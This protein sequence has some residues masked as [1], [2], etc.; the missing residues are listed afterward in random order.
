[1]KKNV[2][3][4]WH[5]SGSAKMGKQQDRLSVV[6]S[7]LKVHGYNNLRV[8]DLSVTPILPR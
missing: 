8:A 2:A 5:V 4:F 1:L 6:G 3:G 7:D